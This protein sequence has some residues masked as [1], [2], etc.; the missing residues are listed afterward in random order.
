MFN[1]MPKLDEFVADTLQ[2]SEPWF[3]ES[4]KVSPEEKLVH[5]NVSVRPDAVF[6]CPVCGQPANRH[7]YESTQRVWRHGDWLFA[8]CLVHCSRP[9]VKC[10]NCGVQQITAPFARKH[11]RFTLFFEGYVMLL[12]PD[13]PVSKLA[14]ALRCDEKS[15]ASILKYWKNKSVDSTD[16]SDVDS[17]ALDETAFKKGHM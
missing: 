16:L 3:V 13:M 5:I 11:S 10:P 14:E 9:R 7:G 17:L 1:L 12:L 4:Y 2:L 8:T 6:V 15:L